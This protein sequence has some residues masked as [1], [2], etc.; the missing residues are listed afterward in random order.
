VVDDE[1]LTYF[2]IRYRY[3]FISGTKASL[4]EQSFGGYVV[5]AETIDPLDLASD[6]RL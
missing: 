4:E 2:I 1:N 5:C 3:R 6:P